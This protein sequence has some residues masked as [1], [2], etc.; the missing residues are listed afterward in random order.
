MTSI[1][2]FEADRPSEYDGNAY[3]DENFRIHQNRNASA[4]DSVSMASE[5]TAP[6]RAVADASKGTAS[7][8]A[9]GREA[10]GPGSVY[11]TGGATAVLEGWR[12]TTVD[13]DLKF[14]PEPPGAFE[15]ILRIKNELDIN[16]ELASPDEA[17]AQK[18]RAF[19]E[20]AS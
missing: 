9:F 3:G 13:V 19:V 6:V 17:F 1:L 20:Q 16:V 8:R 14:D 2:P 5:Y 15:A 11:L 4:H 12:K 10:R 7:I 18:V